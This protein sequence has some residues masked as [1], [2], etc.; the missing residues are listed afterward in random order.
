M[1]HAVQCVISENIDTDLTCAAVAIAPD[2]RRRLDSYLSR[3][4]LCLA[5]ASDRCLTLGGDIGSSVMHRP[6]AFA[7]TFATAAVIGHRAT[8]P[9]P[10]TPKG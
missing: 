4:K 7:A 5:A 2:A 3:L 8:S 6:V 1:F 9:T 10:F